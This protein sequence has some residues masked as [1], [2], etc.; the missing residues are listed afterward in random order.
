MTQRKLIVAH[1]APDLDAITA[2]WL[3]KRF[4]SKNYADAKIA[5]VNPGDRITLEE[6]E[7]SG[8]QLHEVTHVDTGLG[9]FDHHQSE[10]AKQQICAATLVHDYLCRIQPHLENDKALE[11]LVIY[12]NQIDHFQ[13]I[14]WPEVSTPRF[15]FS[16]TELIRGHEFTDPHNDDSQMHFGMQCL[17][18]IYASLKQHIKAAE[19][20][21]EKGQEFIIKEGKALAIETRNDETIKLGQKRGFILV[22]RKD[23][24][25]G[26]IRIKVRPDAIMDLDALH[27]AIIAEDNKGTWFYHGSGKMLINSSRKHRNQTPSPLSLDRVISLIKEI[28]G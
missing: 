13:E 11:E 27:K 21:E 3:L 19:I 22:V 20:I 9:E 12:T 10:R 17:D 26:H 24:K 6:A 28:Y 2:T 18:N 25:L 23:S 7:K 4:D 1:H 14:Y 5:F 8:A 15:S 16:I